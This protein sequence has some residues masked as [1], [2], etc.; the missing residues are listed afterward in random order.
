MIMVWQALDNLRLS[1]ILF[2]LRLCYCHCASHP[3]SGVCGAV[4]ATFYY[5]DLQV[6]IETP[7]LLLASDSAA[8]KP[9]SEHTAASTFRLKCFFITSTFD[10]RLSSFALL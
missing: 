7:V 9:Q 5:L 2:F 3:F 8:L 4:P 10:A 6:Q 1:L